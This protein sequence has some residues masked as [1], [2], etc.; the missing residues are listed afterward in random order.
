M[1]SSTPLSGP[2]K[3]K[4]AEAVYRAL[5]R[6]V[7]A[8]G[9]ARTKP[10]FWTRKREH[11]VPFFHLHLFRSMPCFRV[12]LGVRVLNDGFPAIGLNGPSTA[13]GWHAGARRYEFE[14]ADS[15]A[16]VAACARDL[17]AYVRDVGS[18]WFDAFGD[19]RRL[20]DDPESPLDEDAKRALERSLANAGDPLNLRRSKEL[21]RIEL[22]G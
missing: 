14:F 10:T 11:A 22:D 7:Q 9:F 1:S 12:H 17:A 18:P 19:P 2:I 20:L 5:S 21:L 4:R 13:D 6:E 3:K 16:A 8:L 15:D